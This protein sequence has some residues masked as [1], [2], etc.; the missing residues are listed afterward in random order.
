M[1]RHPVTVVILHITYARTSF[2][3]VVILCGLSSYLY[4]WSCYVLLT[5][6]MY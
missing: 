1:G 3:H 6:L 4:V 2:E 5:I